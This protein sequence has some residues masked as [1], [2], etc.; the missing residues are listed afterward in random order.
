MQRSHVPNANWHTAAATAWLP[1]DS[2]CCNH[3]AIGVVLLSELPHI[4]LQSSE[5]SA[6]LSGVVLLASR[7]TILAAGEPTAGDALGLL[8]AAAAASMM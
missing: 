4:T 5:T 8:S 2:A 1:Q 7:A 6:L 3:A